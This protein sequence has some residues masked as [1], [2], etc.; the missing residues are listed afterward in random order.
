MFVALPLK[1]VAE[2][3]DDL[4]LQYFEIEELKTAQLVQSFCNYF[5]KAS[6]STHSGEDVLPLTVATNVE[7]LDTVRRSSDERYYRQKSLLCD[8]LDRRASLLY[9]G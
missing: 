7:K 4:Q 1:Y 2:G 6:T 8:R 5:D 3:C 9:V